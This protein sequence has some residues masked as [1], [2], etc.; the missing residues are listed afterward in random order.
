MLVYYT[1]HAREKIKL[2]NKYGFKISKTL[3]RRALETP[4]KIES[5]NDSTFI[6][7]DELDKNHVLRVVYRREGDTMIIITIYPGRRK[8]YGL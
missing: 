7:N 8:S 1:K 5:R 3:V 2:L 4:L 6:A